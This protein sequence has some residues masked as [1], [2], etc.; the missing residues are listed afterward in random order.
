MRSFKH[1]RDDFGASAVELALILPILIVLIVGV[2]EVSM[3]LNTKITLTHAAREGARLAAV[4]H[5]DPALVASRAQPL[6]VADGLSIT[7]PTESADPLG[8][9]SVEVVA[10]YP[11]RI[12]IPF[13]PPVEFTLQSAAR[14][15]KE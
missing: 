9:T 10:S 4:G 7:G 11:C 6:R 14:M 5:F 12:G 15:R 8:G 2:V 3:A 1:A 13:C